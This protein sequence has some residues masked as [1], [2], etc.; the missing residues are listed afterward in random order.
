MTVQQTFEKHY[1]SNDGRTLSG[2]DVTSMKN[3]L[4]LKLIVIERQQPF[5]IH[6]SSNDGRTLSGFSGE[7]RRKY[8]SHEVDVI[9]KT[10]TD[11]MEQ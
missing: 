10:E 7:E 4:A 8:E 5:E 1:S 2:M 11:I 9:F 3:Y 6:Y